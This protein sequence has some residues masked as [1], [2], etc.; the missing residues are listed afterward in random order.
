MS[1]IFEKHSEKV[2]DT[3]ITEK[4]AFTNTILDLIKGISDIRYYQVQ[5]YFNLCGNKT[6]G[7]YVAQKRKFQIYMKG[8]ADMTY[9]PMFL[10][11]MLIF[12]GVAASILLGYNGVSILVIYLNLGGN[13]LNSGESFFS[14]LSRMKAVQNLIPDFEENKSDNEIKKLDNLKCEAIYKLNNICIDRESVRIIEDFS[15]EIRENG[16]YLISGMNGSGKST[17]IKLLCGLLHESSGTMYFKNQ[18]ITGKNRRALL[19]TVGY[20]PQNPV[21]FEG[22][23]YHNIF[24]DEVVSEEEKRRIAQKVHLFDFIQKHEAG[25]DFYLKPNGTNIS[26]GER[27]LICLARV[28]AQDRQIVILDEPM[29]GV[30]PKTAAEVENMLMSEHKTVIMVAHDWHIPDRPEMIKIAGRRQ[31]QVD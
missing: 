5:P 30:Y 29:A 1:D 10:M 15:C 27:Q 16:K 6:A 26:G 20:L 14:S 3:Y 2:I 17:L 23:L 12:G 13:I 4:N 21:I 31:Y 9:I 28:L 11:D 25:W 7:K 22:T 8:L 24:F 18:E 19:Q